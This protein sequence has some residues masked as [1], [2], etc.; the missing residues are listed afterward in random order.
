M[1]RRELLRISAEVEVH[2]K[3]YDQF[4]KEY[5][6]DISKGG[7]FIKTEEPFKP[8]TVLEVKLFLPGEK[9]PLNAVGEV[10]HIIDPETAQ[11]RGWEP[12][13]GVHFVD[14]E[15][16]M[17]NRLIKYIAMQAQKKPEIIKDR[18]RHP[19][20]SI[21]IKVRF[22]DLTTLLENYAKDISQGGIFIPTNDPKPIG[23][24]INLTLIHPETEEEVELEGEVVRVVSE[25]DV[26]IYKEKKLVPGMGIKFVN[27][28][29]EQQKAL[30]R[31]VF[32]EYPV[33]PTKE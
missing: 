7:I 2:F 33:D 12:G 22:P 16:T 4:F 27:V 15:E 3:N 14:F 21:R 17:Q 11:E 18:R 30:E 20:T 25:T 13:M 8:Q 6:K 5:S 31:F 29:Q 28:S 24:V 32:V 23:T 26:Q 19:R 10:V 9:E 1:G